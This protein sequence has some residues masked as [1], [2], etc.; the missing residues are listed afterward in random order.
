MGGQP[1]RKTRKMQPA[2]WIGSLNNAIC[3]YGIGLVRSPTDPDSAVIILQASETR[4]VMVTRISALLLGKTHEVYI[5]ATNPFLVSY[6]CES[7]IYEVG[8]VTLI[9][10]FSSRGSYYAKPSPSDE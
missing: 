9:A 2:R 1:Y 8:I 10:D 6:L 4:D 3:A 7:T 5:I